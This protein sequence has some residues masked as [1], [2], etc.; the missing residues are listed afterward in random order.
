MTGGRRSTTSLGAIVAGGMSRR[1]GSPKAL[2]EVGGRPIVRRVRDALAEAVR[3]VVVIANEPELFA[4]L[5]LPIRP[6]EIPGIGALGGIRRALSWARE[7]K[8]RGALCVACDMPFV[9]PALLRLILARAETSKAAAVV[10]ESGGRHGLEPL[11]AWYSVDCISAIDGMIARGEGSVSKLVDRV[12][13]VR[14]PRA[15]VARVGDPD[16]LFLNVNT[17]EDHWRAVLI[18]SGQTHASS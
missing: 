1:F 11:C 10:P 5:D 7:E 8:R 3:D 4:D 18:A 12:V 15:E 9:S 13:E 16:V 6:D 14:V 17:A 2:A